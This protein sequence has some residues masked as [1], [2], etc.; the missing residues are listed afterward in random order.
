MHLTKDE[1]EEEGVARG[2]FA[3]CEPRLIVPFIARGLARALLVH[4]TTGGPAS[5]DEGATHLTDQVERM[6]RP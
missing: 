3:P 6:L 1:A 5:V 2:V 4:I